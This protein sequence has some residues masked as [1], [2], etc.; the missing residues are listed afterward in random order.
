MRAGRLNKYIRIEHPVESQDG[1]GA[2][3]IS[4]AV[5][6]ECWANVKPLSG[7]EYYLAQQ[8]QS[9]ISTE[10]SIRYVPGITTKMRVKYDNRYFNIISVIGHREGGLMCR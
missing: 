7:R 6:L 4:W 5:F 9:E 1:Y 8:I 3:S 10:F 2:E